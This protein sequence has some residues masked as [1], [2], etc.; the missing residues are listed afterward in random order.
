L[1]GPS[2]IRL[3]PLIRTSPLLLL[4]FSLFLNGLCSDSN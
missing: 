3:R 4:S 2:Y 1:Y